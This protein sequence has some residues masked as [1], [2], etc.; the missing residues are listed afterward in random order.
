MNYTRIYG[1]VLFLAKRTWILGDGKSAFSEN[2]EENRDVGEIYKR[3]D[4]LQ[5]AEASWWTHTRI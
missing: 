2:C 1:C 5:M 4:V 3:R